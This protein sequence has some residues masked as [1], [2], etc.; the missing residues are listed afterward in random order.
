MRPGRQIAVAVLFCCITASAQSLFT[1]R[2]EKPRYDI[3]PGELFSANALI[4]PVPLSGL[5]SFGVATTFNDTNASSISVNSPA[6]LDFNGVNGPGAVKAIQSGFAAAKG[7]VDFFKSPAKAYDGSLL[8]TFTFKDLAPG[9]YQLILAPFNTL[10]PTEQI[11]VNGEG[12][13]FDNGI[14]FGSALINYRPLVRLISPING[15]VFDS[16]VSLSV[17]AEASDLDG[18]IAKVEFYDRDTKIGETLSGPYSI[19]LASPA[20]GIHSLYAVALD[21]FGAAKTSAP[22]SITVNVTPPPSERLAI[23][24]GERKQSAK[25]NVLFLDGEELSITGKIHSNS[26][27]HVEGR[28]HRFRDGSVE[29]VTGIF[30]EPRFAG[31]VTFENSVLIRTT[32]ESYP[33][34]YQLQDFAPGGSLAK[35]AQALKRYYHIHGNT[36]LSD[37]ES[38]GVLRDGLY[39]VE[40]QVNLT[41]KALKGRVTIVAT[42]QIKFGTKGGVFEPFSSDLLLF[43]GYCAP[44]H[45]AP[46]IQLHGQSSRWNGIIFA[47]AGGI[48]LRESFGKSADSDKWDG[49]DDKGKEHGHGYDKEEDECRDLGIVGSL[50][51]RGVDIHAKNL[52]LIGVALSPKPQQA[53]KLQLA[54]KAATQS[55]SLRTFATAESSLQFEFPTEPGTTYVLEFCESL[56]NCKWKEL[57]IFEGDGSAKSL[58]IPIEAGDARFFRIRFE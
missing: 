46:S 31:K 7:T 51:G 48:Q 54:R 20:S 36:T 2:F 38:R 53:P 8:A 42:R 3:D 21:N 25:D 23:F 52:Q 58:E 39:Y 15:T 33:V 11:F 6:D 12:I 19:N 26:G 44:N 35:Y 5:S 30:P 24:A 27:I 32:E 49:D 1:I 18:T 50:I 40:G 57:M 13:A 45:H 14:T 41:Q 10:G 29:Y 17:T 56:V 22:V 4:D 9:P 37:Y 47:P 55:E 34:D 16:S 28:N 43:S